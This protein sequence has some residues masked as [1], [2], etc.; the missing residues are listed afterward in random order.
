MEPI[1]NFES[2]SRGDVLHHPALGFAVVEAI[3]GA[4]VELRWEKPGENHPE[5]ATA[6]ALKKG[7]RLCPPGGFLAQSVLDPDELRRI[8]TSEPVRA[9]R[10]LLGD[11][12]EPQRRRDV[13]EWLTN[14]G[15]IAETAFD[16]WW[17]NVRSLIRHDPAFRWEQQA[18]SLGDA[19]TEEPIT[20]DTTDDGAPTVDRLVDSFT[21]VD[22]AEQE[23]ILERLPAQS[24][25]RLLSSALDRGDVDLAVRILAH[26]FDIPP[27]RVEQIRTLGL[28]GQ[29]VLLA[30]LAA[31]GDEETLSALAGAAKEVEGRPLVAEVLGDLTRRDRVR[32][33]LDLLESLLDRGPDPSAAQFLRD[34]LPEGAVQDL[35]RE[36]PPPPT[37]ATFEVVNHLLHHWPRA[38]WWLR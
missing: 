38:T 28:A 14:R 33:I 26:P 37:D 2:V 21:Q 16:R 35:E 27:D 24:V 23:E 11:L 8:T 32:V 18:V 4:S 25:E 7:Y 3:D 13:R 9:L 29:P 36:V 5:R 20:E 15:L 19:P 1:H 30:R 6:G 12:N 31:M 10:L 34:Q 22:D 17:E